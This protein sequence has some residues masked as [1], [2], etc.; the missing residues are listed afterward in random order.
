MD[1]ATSYLGLKLANPLIAGASPLTLD[2]TAMKQAEAAGT[3]AIVMHSLFEEQITQEHMGRIFYNEMYT[4]V[5]AEALSHFPHP[6]RLLVNPQDYLRRIEEMKGAL[7]IPV[8]ASLNCTTRGH[9][10]EYARRVEIAGADALELNIYYLSTN[11]DESSVDVEERV[12]GIV[13]AIKQETKLPVAVKLSPF[14]SSLPNLAKRL[15]AAGASGLVLFN[16]FYQPD[17]DV[18][19]RK[20]TPRLRLSHISDPTELR[21]RLRWIA[22]LSSQSPLSF[23]MTGGVHTGLDV[24]KGIMVGAH[25]AQVTSSILS[26]GPE[27]MASVLSGLRDWMERVHADSV[28]ELRGCMDLSRSADPSAFERANYLNVL[29][30]WVTVP[31]PLHTY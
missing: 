7:T 10:V 17:I 29:N 13:S 26:A 8:I 15:H 24:I 28:T 23:S 22:I 6:D 14:Y 21:L 31:P 18:E 27:Y 16:R 1:L 3:A 20:V 2:V 11:P 9:W 4:N 5:S 25:T 19:T 12:I 30:S